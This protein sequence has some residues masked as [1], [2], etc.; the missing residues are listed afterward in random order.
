MTD[1]PMWPY[2]LRRAW[3]LLA[4][5]RPGRERRARAAVAEAARTAVDTPLLGGLTIR[6]AS[7][8]PTD[9]RA[10]FAIGII[11]GVVRL[12]PHELERLLDA[13]EHEVLRIELPGLFTVPGP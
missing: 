1:R 12:P 13:A 2:P 3:H 8:L 11:V 5:G 9:L 10:D 4:P 7:K 6:Q